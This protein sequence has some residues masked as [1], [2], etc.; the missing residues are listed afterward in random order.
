MNNQYVDKLSPDEL[1]MQFV[2]APDWS[3][4]KTL[5]LQNSELLS[6]NAEK[7]LRSML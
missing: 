3:V 7:S 6:D 1:V 4:S 2:E 5:V